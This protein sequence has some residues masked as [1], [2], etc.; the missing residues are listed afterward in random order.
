MAEAASANSETSRREGMI[1]KSTHTRPD[2]KTTGKGGPLYSEGV[3]V[4]VY[5]R[6]PGDALLGKV[7]A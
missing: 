2:G 5:I 7:V 3:V 1:E 6:R 4:A